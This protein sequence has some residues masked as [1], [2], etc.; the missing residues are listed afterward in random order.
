[1][2]CGADEG[3]STASPRVWAGCSAATA[4]PTTA[5]DCF[6]LSPA[7]LAALRDLLELPLA[8]IKDLDLD[9]PGG[10]EVEQVLTQMLAYHGH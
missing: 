6:T 7:G 4:S 8:D 9:G 3:R 1:M 10:G 2:Q 5:H